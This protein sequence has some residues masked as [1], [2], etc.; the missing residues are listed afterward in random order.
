MIRRKRTFGGIRKFFLW[1]FFLFIIFA[2][3]LG[4][5]QVRSREWLGNERFTMIELT[6]KVE[7]ASFDPVTRRGI[8]FVLPEEMKINTVSGRGAWKV[9][10]LPELKEKYG[11]RWVADSIADTLG[12]GYTVSGRM[13][14]LVDRWNW[15]WWNRRV[16]WSNVQLVG[17]PALLERTEADGE[18]Y[19]EFTSWGEVKMTSWFLSA[20]IAS[21]DVTVRIINLTKVDGLGGHAARTINSV[22]IRVVE[23]KFGDDL[24]DEKCKII[25][26]EEAASSLTVSWMRREFDCTLEI[27]GGYDVGA[28]LILGRE[29]Q[30]WWLGD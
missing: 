4:I 12:I 27:N 24:A 21:E 29:Y 18:K 2:I 14:N 1:V 15:W 26:S 10:V 22:G 6:D 23:V 30:R 7:I 19:Q 13:S 3:G 9:K 5:W 25:S 17:T 28:E 11:Q 20:A 8:R 16:D